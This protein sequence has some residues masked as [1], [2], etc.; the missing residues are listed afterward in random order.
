MFTTI[1]YNTFIT[2]FFIKTEPFIHIYHKQNYERNPAM[3]RN[4]HMA[5]NYTTDKSIILQTLRAK[6][7][8]AKFI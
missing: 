4:K 7:G 8:E 6:H 5:S 2:S 1:L 3:L